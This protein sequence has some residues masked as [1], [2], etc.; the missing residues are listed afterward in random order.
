MINCDA[1]EEICDLPGN[2]NLKIMKD[3]SSGYLYFRKDC[4]SG[5]FSKNLQEN[6]DKRKNFL[7][8]SILRLLCYESAS[9][10][11]ILYLE[12]CPYLDIDLYLKSFVFEHIDILKFFYQCAKGLEYLHSNNTLHR[13]IKPENILINRHKDAELGDLE[14]MTSDSNP[15]SLIGNDILIEL[16]KINPNE[17]TSI[18]S[19]IFCLAKTFEKLIESN[20]A[21]IYDDYQFLK[22]IIENCTQRDPSARYDASE[23]V[24]NLEEEY[25][26]DSR[27]KE[28]IDEF[29]NN[30]Q[31]SNLEEY[32]TPITCEFLKE[33]ENCENENYNKLSEI[34]DDSLL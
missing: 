17:T 4:D 8:P 28:I 31:D 10:R 19:D 23:L 16:S 15:K 27:L 34:Y 26:K 7:Y 11:L 3:E 30:A 22:R 25:S 13:D 21:D 24:Q 29:N 1:L 18:K 14:Y 12:F 6:L 2:S 32:K 5:N 33:F 20:A 9:E